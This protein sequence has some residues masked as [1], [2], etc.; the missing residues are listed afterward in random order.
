MWS[1]IVAQPP[2]FCHIWVIAAAM[3]QLF[4]FSTVST[5]LTLAHDALFG[6]SCT[7]PWISHL[8]HV[9]NDADHLCGLLKP[10]ALCILCSSLVPWYAYSLLYRSKSKEG[11]SDRV[12]WRNKWYVLLGIVTYVGMYIYD[13]GNTSQLSDLI[14]GTDPKLD[15]LLQRC[16]TLVRGPKPPIWFSNRHLQFVPWLVQNELHMYMSEL[17]F[18]R[19]EF[20]VTDCVD[21]SIP[22]CMWDDTM[23]DTITLDVF[24]PLD[25]DA[26]STEFNRS[27]PVILFAP[28]LTC[29]SQDLPSSTIIRAVYGKGFRS[30]VVNRRGHTPGTVLKAPRWDLFGD[31]D[32]L[33]QVYWHIKNHL[34]DPDT[35][36]F[37]HGISSGCAVVAT[38]VGA[39]DKR[40][41][42][43]PD[44]PSP[45]FVGV[46]LVTP[47]YDT[48]KVLRPERFKWPYNPMIA[49]SVKDHFLMKNER[50]LRKFNSTAYDAAMEAHSLQDILEASAPFAGYPDAETYYKFT[51]PVNDMHHITTPLYVMNAID[52]P[53]CRI[54]NLYEQSPYPQHGG[55][56]Y[57]DIVSESPRG[58]IAVTKTGSHCPFLDGGWW[59]PFVRDPVTDGWMLNS[60]VDQSVVEFYDAA[61]RVYD[62]RRFL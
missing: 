56:S 5:L 49:L 37:L 30:I 29:H 55:K 7:S 31:I 23:N 2:I 4:D 53:C 40:A 33:E 3:Q 36:M 14:T 51:N 59:Y 58:I 8:L 20:T 48:S 32:D 62:E 21:K 43:E 46:T 61:L 34:I 18:Q 16:P 24:P 60:W 19:I 28:G 42:L 47:G 27:T 54:D 38:A 15:S 41:T 39:W 57:A 52:D 12:L 17:N 13:Q 45:S 10:I 1:Q 44:R 25:S 6:R 35:P 22:N 9:Y 11:G 26:E 50:I